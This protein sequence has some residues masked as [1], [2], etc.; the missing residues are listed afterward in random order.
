M[1]SLGILKLLLSGT[2]FEPTKR[3]YVSQH[4]LPAAHPVLAAPLHR[5]NATK[6]FDESEAGQNFNINSPVTL[7]AAL[8]ILSLGMAGNANPPGNRTRAL[9][10]A[11]RVNC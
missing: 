1:A 7:D 9:D 6:A 10:N 5:S 2:E 3:L 4:S 8:S 11:T